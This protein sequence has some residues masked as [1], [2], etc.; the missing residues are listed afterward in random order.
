ML[1]CRGVGYIELPPMVRSKNC[2]NNFSCYE[3]PSALTRIQIRPTE[4][5]KVFRRSGMPETAMWELPRPPRW[6]AVHANTS[7]SRSFT[8]RASGLASS[9]VAQ[10]PHNENPEYANGRSHN[11]SH[12]HLFVCES[13]C[14]LA[15]AIDGHIM[16]CGT[17]GSYHFRDCKAL[18]VTSLTHV[19]GAIASVQTFT[20]TFS[21]CE[22]TKL[23]SMR[24]GHTRL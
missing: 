1:H 17:I 23:N 16:R 14:P 6:L 7:G 12:H 18:L 9:P 24:A 5:K 8:L 19:S 4:C 21:K 3:R 2:R 20:F 11:T 13:N 10:S 22:T 15:R